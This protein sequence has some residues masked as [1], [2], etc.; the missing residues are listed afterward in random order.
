MA[1]QDWVPGIAQ[2]A[3]VV[4]AAILS[5]VGGWL[6]ARPKAK[7][8][9]TTA[10]A[11]GFQVL[12]SELQEESKSLRELVKE[13]TAAMRE[14]TA[15]ISVLE[16]QVHKLDRHVVR[17]NDLLEKAGIQPPEVPHAYDE[18]EPKDGWYPHES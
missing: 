7:A 12:V 18:S 3:A 11:S 15:R 17:L 4:A 16:R 13:Q 9:V 5:A 14:Q 1:S 10:I 6:V 8:D 2:A